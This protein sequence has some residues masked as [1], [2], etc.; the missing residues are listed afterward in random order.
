MVLT[1]AQTR[2]SNCPP[3]W[4]LDSTRQPP[5]MA[6]TD[7][8][9]REKG[10][11]VVQKAALQKNQS[12]SLSLCAPLSRGVVRSVPR[13]LQ[14]MPSDAPRQQFHPPVFDSQ[15]LMMR[16]GEGKGVSAASPAGS[17]VAW[18]W[19][20]AGGKGRLPGVSSCWSLLGSGWSRRGSP[21]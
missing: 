19:S 6:T 14:A 20:C 5:L 1:E 9:K 3:A 12:P 10:N 4:L 17:V 15:Q 8:R 21:Q 2:S 16:F 11:R 13:Y 7:P 18:T